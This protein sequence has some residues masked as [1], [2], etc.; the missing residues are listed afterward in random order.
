MR[1]HQGEVAEQHGEVSTKCGLVAER[2]SISVPMLCLP[3]GGRAA[4]PQIRLIHH[5]VVQQCELMQQ[6]KGRGSSDHLGML[7]PAEI[8]TRSY[9]SPMAHG[10]PQPLTA[11]LQKV[12][13]PCRQIPSEHL[14]C[15]SATQLAPQQRQFVYLLPE[16]VRHAGQ[17]GGHVRV[18]NPTWRGLPPGCF[19]G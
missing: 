15:L 12:I 3:V 4:T 18:L 2:A 7:G 10:R 16:Q 8:S 14:G 17:G 19:C 1:L 9:V 6:L 11:L 5:I 13:Q